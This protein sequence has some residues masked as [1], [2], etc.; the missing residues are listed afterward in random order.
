LLYCGRNKAANLLPALPR[1]SRRRGAID[2]I[3]QL[4]EAAKPVANRPENQPGQVA[5]FK[6]IVFRH[7]N[8]LDNVARAQDVRELNVQID[9]RFV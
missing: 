6:L 3:N 9:K 4:T 8:A 5:S 1:T 2:R 7:R